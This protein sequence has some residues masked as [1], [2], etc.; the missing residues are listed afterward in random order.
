MF[1][2]IL[3]E[4]IAWVE[5]FVRFVPGRVGDAIRRLW[6]KMRFRKCEN[7]SIGTGCR[8]L[9]PQAISME[10]SVGIGPNSFFAAQGGSI[11]VGTNTAFNANVHINASVG[12]RI[13]I[14]KWCLIGPNVVMRTADHRY[15]NQ[16]LFIRQQGH[17]AGDIVIE[18]DVWIG[19]S[20]VI[21]GD[22]RIGSGAIVGAGAVV[23]K[24]VQ[25][26]SI[27][28]GVPAKVIKFRGPEVTKND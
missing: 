19:A 28:A 17:L 23:T 7:V 9:Y 24:N 15:D 1:K 3:E 18:D 11:S 6:F 5:A 14:G 20:A 4:I 13:S 8:F 16:Q 26:M 2:K 22:V 21:L 27:V 12:G 10:G 25:S